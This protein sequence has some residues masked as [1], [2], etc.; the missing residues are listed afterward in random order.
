MEKTIK[1]NGMM[2]P[3]CEMHVKEALEAIDGVETAVP[4][5]TANNAVITLSADV[6]DKTLKAAVEAAGYQWAE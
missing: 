1:I 6:P 4:S 2:C 5:H 3:H